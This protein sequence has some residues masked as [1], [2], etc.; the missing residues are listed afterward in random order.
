VPGGGGEEAPGVAEKHGPNPR[1]SP[2]FARLQTL[3]LQRCP[4]V[5][6]RALLGLLLNLRI[7]AA[8]KVDRLQ[9]LALAGCVV[10]KAEGFILLR[11]K[12]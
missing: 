11:T 1:P 3:D 7:G 12:H 10:D 4:G 6:G 9:R 8:P 2:A 5:T